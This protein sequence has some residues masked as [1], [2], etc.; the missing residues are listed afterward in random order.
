[1]NPCG[2]SGAALSTTGTVS[3]KS[4]STSGY[5]PVMINLL[6]HWLSLNGLHIIWYSLCCCFVHCYFFW[7]CFCCQCRITVCTCPPFNKRGGGGCNIKNTTHW[8]WWA[9]Q[10]SVMNFISCNTVCEWLTYL[11][12]IYMA[13][14]GNIK[15]SVTVYAVVDQKKSHKFLFIIFNPFILWPVVFSLHAPHTCIEK[16]EKEEEEKCRKRERI[17]SRGWEGERGLS[18]VTSQWCK[19]WIKTYVVKEFQVL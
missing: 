1:M 19:P 5:A 12:Y 2:R 15:V 11:G 17:K 10:C 9:T 7:I 14:Q 6:Q 8:K 18:I 3:E 4:W 16:R 13:F